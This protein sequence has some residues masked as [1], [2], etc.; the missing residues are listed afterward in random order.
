MTSPEAA[1]A[2][3]GPGDSAPPGHS[4]P[5]GPW[6]LVSGPHQL[7]HPTVLDYFRSEPL[8][9]GYD[10][11]FRDNEL[12]RCDVAFAEETLGPPG[13][14]LDLGCGTGRHLEHFAR[15]GWQVTGVDLSEPML[16]RAAAKLGRLAR[17]R[18]ELYRAD[19][20]DLSFLP[21]GSFQAVIC[22]FSTLGMLEGAEL[23]QRALCQAARCL[24]PGG[25]LVLHVHNRLHFLRW[26]AGRRELAEAF[27]RRL[28]GGAP[29][30]DCV[31][32]NY[33]GIQDLYL[34]TFTLG[35]LAGLVRRA[36]L[37]V[38]RAVPLNEARNAEARG[39]INRLTANGFL[40][41][42]EKRPGRK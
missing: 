36:G 30:G 38:V 11:H 41:A 28:A 25:R 26:A 14:L 24:A 39:L 8:A 19:L 29:F 37:R 3:A 31:M 34:H 32:R 33:R 40:L 17:A 22:M 1:E 16:G 21:A 27:I 5:G 42:A 6:R 13:R 2:P 4:A 9:D 10:D 35:E 20:L 15:R 18:W 7:H 12:F 23:R